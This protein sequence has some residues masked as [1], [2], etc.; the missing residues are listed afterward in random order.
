[1]I[2]L[3]RNKTTIRPGVDLLPEGEQ[4][5]LAINQ[6][7]IFANSARRSLRFER[8][9]NSAAALAVLVGI[10]LG[11][12]VISHEPVADDITASSLLVGAT[13]LALFSEGRRY[14]NLVNCY[15]SSEAV[16]SA[17]SGAGIQSPRWT[18]TT[19]FTLKT[20]QSEFQA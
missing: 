9:R 8:T 4:R 3:R 11:V 7:D 16:I 2:T 15:N 20:I 10:G 18:N 1:M 5:E 14:K 19:A 13:A 12:E 17:F 6:T